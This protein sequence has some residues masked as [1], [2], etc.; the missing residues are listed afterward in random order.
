[1]E[2][3][4]IALLAVTLLILGEVTYL[5][6]RLPKTSIKSKERPILI[7][8]SVL[9]D[10][11]ITSIASTGF[12]G[13]ALV[14]PRSVVGELQFLADNA[15]ADKRARA[16]RGLDVITELQAMPMVTVEVLQDGSK[17]QEGVDERLLSLAKQYTAVIC[18][19][20]YNLN[21]VAAVEGIPVLNINELAQSL[22]MAYL[23]G[24]HMMVELVQKGQD[25]H[26]GVGYLADGTMVVVE[27]ASNLIGQTVSVEVIRSLQTA[28][29]KMMFARRASDKSIAKP[30]QSR[31]QRSRTQDSSHKIISQ[32]ES[33]SPKKIGKNDRDQR[34]F[35]PRQKLSRSL[36][37]PRRQD[38]ESA[39]I[40]LVEKQ[41]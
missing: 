15:D 10:G 25:S 20:D 19:I 13:G 17:A 11:R 28:A 29:G 21:K 18:T 16:R 5:L 9:M 35:V 14:I 24:E 40:D 7:D 37:S 23:P 38:R 26:Q 1:M 31:P 34:P 22:R 30:T 3:K 8:T 33:V 4:D 32:K 27:Q 41:P 2:T 12:M 36:S 39:L 6:A